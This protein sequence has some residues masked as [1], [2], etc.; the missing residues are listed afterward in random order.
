MNIDYSLSEAIKTTNMDEVSDLLLIY[1]IMCQYGVHMDRCFQ[2]ASGLGIPTTLNL[3]KAIGLFHVHGH[4]DSCLYRFATTYIPGVGMIDGEILETLWSIL[5]DISRSVRTATL[6]TRGELLDDHMGNS[7][8]KK[9]IQICQSFY[10][11]RVCL[12]IAVE[13]HTI[14]T[15]YKRALDGTVE[16][17]KYFGELTDSAPTGKAELWEREI[18]RAESRRYADPTAMDVMNSR[19]PKRMLDYF[20]QKIF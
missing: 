11:T 7:N 6:A 20:L 3:I 9:I 1:D 19:V 10:S 15:K 13:G 8:W 14:R 18:R 5:N 17:E 16:A 2:D 12:L 4:Q